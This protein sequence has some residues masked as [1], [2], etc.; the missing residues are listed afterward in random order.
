MTK[1]G[2]KILF[3]TSIFLVFILLGTKS[4]LAQESCD[5]T[6]DSNAA[7]YQS[8]L[9]KLTG[10]CSDKVSQLQGQANTLSNQIA[11]FNAQINL[12]TLKIAQTQ[13]QI[14]LLGGRIDQLGSSLDDLT[15]AFSSRAVETYK[16][17]RFESNFFFI[18]SASDISDAVQRSHDL[19]KI[20]E[21]DRSLLTKLTEAQTTYQGEKQ[22]QETLQKQLQAQ[23]ANLDNQKKAKA[24]LLTQTQGSENKYK[25]LLAQAQSELASFANFADSQGGASL[26]SNQ[27]FCDGWGCYYNQRDSQWGNI[28]INGRS[29]CP[30][31]CSVARVGCLVTSVAMMV[32]HQGHKDILPSDIALSD[33][34]NFSVDTAYLSYPTINVK[35]VNITRSHVGNSLSPGMVSSGPVIVGI[36]YGPFGTHFVV[37]KSYSNGT[38]YMDD[39]FTAGGHDI[40]FTDHYS[41]DSVF[42]V[43]TISI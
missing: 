35:G 43:E 34:G 3:L 38:Y 9:T 40:P 36:K 4:I 25:T 10:L 18:I 5:S 24:T 42:D 12:A 29:D 16:L 20:E 6:C 7:D 23:Q 30:G 15:K 26:L 21:A 11:Q 19:Q 8:C 22:D 32:S 28:L 13:A 2:K 17:S 14:A 31:N 1:Y 39:P 37:V 33:S 27:T 41:L